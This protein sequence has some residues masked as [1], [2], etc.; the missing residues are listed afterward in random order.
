MAA[1]VMVKSLHALHI[2]PLCELT[3]F[4]IKLT[5]VLEVNMGASVA[6]VVFG[7]FFFISS[8]T[9][10][11]ITSLS[12]AKATAIFAKVV[13]SLAPCALRDTIYF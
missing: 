6:K 5:T 9:L 12:V 1:L 4:W 10:A 8:L 13:L 3:L 7:R 11:K 2:I